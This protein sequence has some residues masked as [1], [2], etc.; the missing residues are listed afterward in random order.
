MN[1]PT[2]EGSGRQQKIRTKE[3]KGE[4]GL[5]VIMIWRKPGQHGNDPHEENQTAFFKDEEGNS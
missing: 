2:E 5:K 3:K 4:E 1:G